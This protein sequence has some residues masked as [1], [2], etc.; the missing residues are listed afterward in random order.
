MFCP[1]TS[2]ASS[3]SKTRL[4]AKAKLSI[5]GLAIG[6]ITGFVGIGGGFLI[7]PALLIL[8]HLT[9]K[10]AIGT[11]LSIIAMQ[12]LSGFAKHAFLLKQNAEQ[13]NWMLIILITVFSILGTLAGF[14]VSKRMSQYHL[15]RLFGLLLLPLSGFVLFNNI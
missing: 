7:I 8:S 10:Q 11:S 3:T 4:P 5:A 15:K 9:M 2:D 13:L 12:S 6:L 1:G 14:K